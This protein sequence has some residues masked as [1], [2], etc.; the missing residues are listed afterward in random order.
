MKKKKTIPA[1]GKKQILNNWQIIDRILD[2]FQ[3]VFIKETKG[4]DDTARW[5]ILSRTVSFLFSYHFKLSLR[6]SDKTI[7]RINE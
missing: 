3:D 6:E 4:M 5:L 2:G 7:R 1:E